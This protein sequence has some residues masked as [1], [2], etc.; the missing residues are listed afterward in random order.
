[1]FEEQLIEDLIEW[2]DKKT[3]AEAPPAGQLTLSRAYRIIAMGTAGACAVLGLASYL[4]WGDDGTMGWAIVLWIV[5]TAAALAWWWRL[6]RWRLDYDAEG[7]RF[8]RALLPTKL[9]RWDE[10]RALRY[11]RLL[12]RDVVLVTDTRTLRIPTRFCVGLKP[13][14]RAVRHY[15]PQAHNIV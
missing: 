11:H 9:I 13:F 12:V 3:A 6:F 8:R 1:M 5:L 14:S 4:S 10:V 7:I 2:A 15:A